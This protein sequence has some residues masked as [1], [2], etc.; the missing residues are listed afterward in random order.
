MFKDHAV[1]HVRAGKG[2]DGC[3]SFLRDK[4][5]TR[6][7]PD[8]GDGGHGGNIVFLADGGMSTLLPLLRNPHIRSENGESGRGK[9]QHGKR[10]EPTVVKVPVG[11]LIHE[12]KSGVLLRDL[13][14]EGDEVVVAHGGRG[15]WGNTHFAHA[16]DQAPRKFNPGTDGE[17]KTLRLEL[18]LI[19]DVG[20]VGLPN[21][22]KS[23]LIGRVSA[24]R[25]RVADYP[26]TTLQPHPGIVELPGFRRFVMVDI[27]GLIEGASEGHGLGHRFLKHVERTRAL[28]HLVE[29]TPMDESD[30][31]ENWRKIESELA[32]YSPALAAKPRITVFSKADTVPHPD[33]RV[34]ELTD[35]LNIPA[36][37]AMS[38]VTGHNIDRLLEDAWRLIHP[39]NSDTESE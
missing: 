15:G 34:K 16:L 17:E 30:P 36:T 6:G 22:G 5:T 28:I 31:A 4:N 37:Y 26:F 14:A 38:G 7:G 35:E 21:A 24:A 10:G 12:K 25:P 23:T 27:P 19:A 20:L 32:R 39:E 11:T 29:L 33:A 8:G 3:S 9:N 13:K 18:K 1:V 2:G